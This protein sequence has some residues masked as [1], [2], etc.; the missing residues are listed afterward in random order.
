MEVKEAIT[1]LRFV[2]ATG[3]LI[4][5]WRLYRARVTFRAPCFASYC[6]LMVVDLCWSPMSVWDLW[7]IEPWLLTLR[8]C[9]IVEAASQ[10]TEVAVW[11]RP[12]IRRYLI[13]FG[14]AAALPAAALTRGLFPGTSP[15]S[16]YY[17][18][19]QTM[20]VWMAFGC[21]AMFLCYMLDWSQLDRRAFWHFAL[22]TVYLGLLT[23]FGMV[24]P[25]DWPAYYE[26]R[27]WWL[28]ASGLCVAV[29]IRLASQ[30]AR[31][32]PPAS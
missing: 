3:Y 16:W 29:W 7:T 8:F 24:K 25:P 30:G 10:A 13:L 9:S 31:S 11:H 22:L 17:S 12:R 4:L 6:A 27:I 21:L 32:V 2:V 26:P 28:A 14:L 19:R 18:I 1:A 15:M 20:H 23:G 5:A